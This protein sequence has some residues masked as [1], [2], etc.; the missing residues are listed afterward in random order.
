MDFKELQQLSTSSIHMYAVCLA[1]FDCRVSSVLALGSL[2]LTLLITILA[3]S[4]TSKMVMGTQSTS[5]VSTYG[6]QPLG[7]T[8]I[9]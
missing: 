1:L 9:S 4:T 6:S 5:V 2:L 7:K 8:S 3:G